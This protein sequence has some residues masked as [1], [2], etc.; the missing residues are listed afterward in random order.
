M[1]VIVID[2]EEEEHRQQD[3]VA[4]K[5]LDSLE[6]SM[7]ALENWLE[8]KVQCRFLSSNVLFLCVICFLVS[9]DWTAL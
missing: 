4:Y 6:Q 8:S 1:V 9:C 3:S 7:S 2:K 5:R